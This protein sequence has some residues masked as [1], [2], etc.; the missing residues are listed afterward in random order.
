MTK[1]APLGSR[2][3]QVL[4][5]VVGVVMIVAGSA[6]ATLGAA[7]LP[8]TGHRSPILDSELRFYAVWYVV[9]GLTLWRAKANIVEQAWF[10][11]T[12]GLA[13]F[14][15][16]LSRIVSWLT[17]GSPHWTQVVLLVIELVIPLVIIPW[18]AVASRPRP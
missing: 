6:T 11:R 2:G 1:D 13:F 16:G 8:D 17:L 10:I 15:A 12:V 5:G 7:S 18:Q 3:L 9:A 4:L 14:V